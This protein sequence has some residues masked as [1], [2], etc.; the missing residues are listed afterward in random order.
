[1]DWNEL[2]AFLAV[3]DQE[4]FS[5]AARQL[6]LTQPAI[7]KRIQSLE[8][9]LGVRLFDRVGKRVYL[10]DAG[11]LL[12]PRAEGILR[13]LGD[14]QTLLRNLHGRIEGTLSLATSHHVG[15]HRLAPVL[16]E[17]SQRFPSV[18]LDIKF[19]DSEVAHD[20]VAAADAELAV[21]TLDPR[22]TRALD[23]TRLWRDPLVFT[24]ARDHEL[25]RR[26]GP[27]TLAELAAEHAI[28]PGLETFTG[29][30]VMGL[31][32]EAGLT[33]KTSMSTNYLETI[34]MLVGIGLGW[35]VLPATLLS[36]QMATL[37]V[38]A[39]SLERHLGRVTNPDRTLS[40]A[41]RAFVEV[42][43]RHRD[44]REASQSGF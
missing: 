24:A 8:A 23:S 9:A 34:A 30:I 41:A 28:L 3:A 18:R 13:E 20:M 25:A 6:H 4:S 10:T 12:R 29:R 17:F 14:A 26:T 5:N 39:P 32:A 15:L 35:S 36:E 11:R 2:R 7:S 42:L 27:I 21:V 22:A 44:G 16:K 19:V 37:D 38:H 43:D 33:I 31:F 1:M 40:N